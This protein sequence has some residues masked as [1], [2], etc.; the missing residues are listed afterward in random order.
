MSRAAAEIVGFGPDFPGPRRQTARMDAPRYIHALTWDDLPD[1]IRNRAELCLLDLIGIAIGGTTTRLSAI[2]RNH[3][4]NQFGGPHPMLFDARATSAA[5]LAL[6]SAMSI[7]ALDGHDGY[8]PAKGHVGCGLFPAALACALEAG[9]TNGPEFLTTIV[10]GYELGSRLGPAL[11]AT[12]PDYHTSGAWIAVAGAA[13]GARLLNL[14]PDQTAHALG[15]A[16]Y[17]GPRSQMMRCIDH[18]TMLKDGSGWGAMAGVSAALLARDGFSGAPAVTLTDPPEIWRDL[19]SRWLIAE[20]Y[21]KPYPVCRWAQ[22]PIEAAL[23][24]RAQHNLAS[25]DIASVEIATFHESTRLAV[26]EPKSTE[27]AQYSTSFPTA[28]A[29]VRGGV[30]PADISDSSLQ[31]PE[32]L[33]LSR[34]MTMIE[35]A[36]A[37]VAFPHRRLGRVTLTLKDGTK[38]ASPHVIPKWDPTAPPTEAELRAKFHNLADPLVGLPRAN[39]IE[40]ALHKL[41]QN[42]LLPLYNQLTQP[43]SPATTAGKSA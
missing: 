25:T 40:S 2:I 29:L 12:T 34:A 43:I 30:T 20:Q 8:N 32:I 37:N 42:G 5:G 19:G 4:T 11:H 16:E 41:P 15:I 10:M 14:D 3:A 38:L 36:E 31:D 27:E 17:H 35:D 1:D 22:S 9:Q 26:N 23:S 7:D 13:A 24:L 39:A 28:V 18:P 21:F 6:A 33:R